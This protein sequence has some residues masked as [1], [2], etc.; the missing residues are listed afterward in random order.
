M[1]NLLALC[2][3]GMGGI[4]RFLYEVAPDIF[5]QGFL[6]DLEISLWGMYFEERAKAK[7]K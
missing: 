5:P 4:D 3:G 6:T 1:R 2:S 7:A